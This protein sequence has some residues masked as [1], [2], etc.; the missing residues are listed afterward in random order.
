MRLFY[1]LILLAAAGAVA[2]FAL[3]NPEQLT[4]HFFDRSLTQSVPVILGAT[5]LLGMI[6]GWTIIGLLRRSWKRVTEPERQYAN[7]R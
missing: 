4:L 7:S 5:Y 3:E 6:S 2:L 1:L